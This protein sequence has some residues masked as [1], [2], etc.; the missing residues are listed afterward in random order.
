MRWGSFIVLLILLS[1]VSYAAWPD[2]NAI[3]DAL[4]ETFFSILKYALS[5]FISLAN[6]FVAYNPVIVE[7]LLA[8]HSKVIGLLVP[9][10]LII[11]TWNGIQIMASTAVSTQANARITI[12]NSVISMILV[13]SSLQIYN[14]LLNLSQLISSYFI[15]APFPE[16]GYPSITTLALF[17][18]IVP[19]LVLFNAFLIIR[20]FFI[21]LGVLLFPIGIFL[22]FF[23]PTKPYGRMLISTIFFFL[24]IQVILSLILSIMGI[25]AATPPQSV[26]LSAI[27]E[28]TYKL[29]MFIGGLLL[30]LF[31]P[32]MLILQI[33]LIALYPEIKL[34][35]LLGRA[36]ASVKNTEQ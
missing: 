14:L 5:L 31:I 6:S 10:Y 18:F 9:L 23:P 15:S 1:S 34:L 11:L 3:A 25:L 26:G 13:A 16:V 19:L 32:T 21:S 27:D 2:P 35:G 4:V 7:A 12:Q 29:C 17:L 22:Y 28:Q 33:L 8:I 30:L 24:F 20:F 36:G